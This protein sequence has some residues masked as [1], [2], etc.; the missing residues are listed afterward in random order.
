MRLGRDLHGP[1][2]WVVAAGRPERA[3]QQHGRA[4]GR[5]A[6]GGGSIGSVHNGDSFRAYVMAQMNHSP[7]V[8]VS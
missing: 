5:E 2:R 1:F 6:P 4:E 7:A 3:D 8:A